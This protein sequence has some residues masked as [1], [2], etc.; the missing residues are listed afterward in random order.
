MMKLLLFISLGL[1]TLSV[2]ILFLEIKASFALR[3]T[4]SEFILYAITLIF[5]LSVFIVIV[6]TNNLKKLNSILLLLSLLPCLIILIAMPG[7]FMGEGCITDYT[8]PSGRYSIMIKERCGIIACY[9]LHI[10]KNN[11]LWGD[12]I[13]QIE[14]NGE[15][16]CAQRT[17][18]K[19]TWNHDETQVQWTVGELH[20]VV[21]IN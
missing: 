12:E 1:Q 18:T 6:S 8:S 20:G 21:N 5:Y 2:T 16:S 3:G 17:R 14:T 11:F 4:Y 13:G 15:A 19:V 9:P 7:S 10:Y